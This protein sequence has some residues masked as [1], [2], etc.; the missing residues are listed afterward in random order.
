MNEGYF[1][2]VCISFLVSEHSLTLWIILLYHPATFVVAFFIP[3]ES[4]MS[5]TRT[6]NKIEKYTNKMK[7]SKKIHKNT[8]MSF[9]AKEKTTLQLKDR[10]MSNEVHN[11]RRSSLK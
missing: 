11:I 4:F 2:I 9:L 5:L 6:K 1:P 3:T 8:E 7:K 10:N